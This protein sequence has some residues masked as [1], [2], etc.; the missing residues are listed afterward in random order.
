MRKRYEITS[1][2][3][4]S[5][6]SMHTGMFEYTMNF[7]EGRTYLRPIWAYKNWPKLMCFRGNKLQQVIKVLSL[8]G[9]NNEPYFTTNDWIPNWEQIKVIDLFK[10]FEK[11]ENRNED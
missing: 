7:G 8:S 9:K 6:N 10:F 3:V 2:T 5:D 11:K 4:R 1:V